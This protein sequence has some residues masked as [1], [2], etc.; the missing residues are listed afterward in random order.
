V[1]ALTVFAADSLAAWRSV[2]AR[3]QKHP[4]MTAWFL[5][6]LLAATW[7]GLRVA[8]LV[9]TQ[10]VA[11]GPL[12][13]QPHTLLLVYFM[14]MTGKSVVDTN[15]RVTQNKE[16]LLILGQPVDVYSA[17]WGKFAYI[18][19]GNLAVLSVALGTATVVHI[20]LTPGLPV[21]PWFVACLVPLTLLSTAMGFVLSILTSQPGLA[22]RTVLVAVF[23]ELAAALYFSFDWLKGEPEFL[24]PASML[25]FAAALSCVPPA[26]RLFLAA[27]NYETSGS[28]GLVQ[29]ATRTGSGRLF[30]SLTRR[31]QPESRE[32][33]RKEM[34]INISRKEVGG[35]LFTVIGLA[36]VLVYLRGR[37]DSPDSVVEPLGRLVLPLLVCVGLFIA[38]VLQYA[39]LGLS[40]LGKEG[41][42]FWIL[43]HLPVRSERI[44]EAKAG[45]L[46]VFT[47]VMV[48][49]VALPLPI[50]SGMGPA[51]LAFFVLAALALALAF[52]AVGIWSGTVYPNFDEGTRGTPDV[53]TM[54]LIMMACLFLSVLIVGLPGLVMYYDKP[55]GVLC[56]ALSA[57]WCALFLYHAI[58]RSARNY[59]ALEVGV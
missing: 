9:A 28:E 22:R 11:A 31:M 52:T 27:W 7:M 42:N 15:S 20:T 55:I 24:V 56:M 10:S 21:P 23:S 39:M 54:Y 35:T 59:D 14:I 57:D 48:F 47:P 6:L 3:L 49:A 29:R 26:S 30:S 4:A 34:V 19:L 32:L 17:L 41:S 45:A 37:M 18:A 16:M 44:F 33:L 53:M 38:A 43:K 40:S 25:L 58:R 1:A 12:D 51:W 5:L 46:L 36:F 2:V 13:I 8:E 50:M